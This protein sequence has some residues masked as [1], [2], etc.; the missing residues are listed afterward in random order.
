MSTLYKSLEHNIK[1]YIH[2]SISIRY[3]AIIAQV[4]YFGWPNLIDQDSV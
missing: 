3:P 1:S 2:E 4:W